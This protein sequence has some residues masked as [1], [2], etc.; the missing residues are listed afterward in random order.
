MNTWQGEAKGN[1]ALVTQGQR[2]V[3]SGR[4]QEGYIAV[5][6]DCGIERRRRTV[7]H[8]NVQLWQ[9]FQRLGDLLQAQ[10]AVD[11]RLC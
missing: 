4:L 3:G 9:L 10:K 1:R 7:S 11:G 5:V 8:L 6:V 2:E